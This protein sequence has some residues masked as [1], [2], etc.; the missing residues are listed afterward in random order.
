MLIEVVGREVVY[1]LDRRP[2][3]GHR[4]A[5]DDVGRARH[6]EPERRRVGNA[7]VGVG[8][9]DRPGSEHRRRELAVDLV[10][11]DR[12]VVEEDRCRGRRDGPRYRGAVVCLADRARRHGPCGI[13]PVAGRP[14][15]EAVI[16]ERGARLEPGRLRVA[17]VDAE[18]HGL[19]GVDR[20]QQS[21]GRLVR[22]VTIPDRGLGGGPG[23]GARGDAARGRR[24][25]APCR[26]VGD[27][28]RRGG[29]ARHH[30]DELGARAPARVRHG[31]GRRARI[32]AAGRQGWYPAGDDA[33]RHR[34]R[35]ERGLRR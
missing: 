4:G 23:R 28:V 9:G 6:V 22:A 5:A 2:G 19:R 34:G 3:V 27:D 26:L 12:G 14:G 25:P 18:P 13:G 20:R 17:G 33:A 24:Q 7:R 15:A 8:V 21:A 1:D 16:P 29:N 35:A 32:R 30:R 11:E 31:E 10:A